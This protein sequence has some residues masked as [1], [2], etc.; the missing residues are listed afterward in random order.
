ME[1]ETRRRKAGEEQYLKRNKEEED[2]DGNF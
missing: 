1:T 2:I